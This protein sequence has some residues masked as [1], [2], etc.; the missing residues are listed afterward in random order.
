VIIT[1]NKYN[2]EIDNSKNNI[3]EVGTLERKGQNRRN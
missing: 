2:K 3:G 1:Y